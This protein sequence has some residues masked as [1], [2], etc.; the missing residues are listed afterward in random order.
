MAKEE[1][2]IFHSAL[3]QKILNDGIDFFNKTSVEPL[4]PGYDFE[5][6]G[7]YGLYYQGDFELYSSISTK[8]K[9]SMGTPIYIGKAVPPGSRKARVKVSTASTLY[10]RL[11]EHARSIK[12]SRNL[13]L[14]DFRCRFMVMNGTEAD[15]IGAMESELIR[16]YKPL[17]NSV[18][19]G[20]GNHTPGNGRFEQARSEW[21]TIHPGRTWADKCK[22][23]SP[24]IE[25]I[26]KRV[27]DLD[28]T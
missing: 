2:H 14:S 6:S 8:N 5:G 16:T 24:N 13:K 10:N 15:L 22:G 17:W 25:Q 3:A 28:K 18:V 20:F 4:P 19:Y 26:I 7:V 27:K 21:D 11:N 23:M 9:K 1:D 12:E